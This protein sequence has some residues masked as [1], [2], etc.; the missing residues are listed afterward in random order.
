PSISVSPS[1]A[2]GNISGPSTMLQPPLPL[3]QLQSNCQQRPVQKK[4]RCLARIWSTS[5]Y[6]HYRFAADQIGTHQVLKPKSNVG[7]VRRYTTGTP[8]GGGFGDSSF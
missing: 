1:P 6:P 8:S 5:S 3:L 7:N 4:D 2:P